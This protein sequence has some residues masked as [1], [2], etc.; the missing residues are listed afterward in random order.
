MKYECQELQGLSL[1]TEEIQK[2]IEISILKNL[3]K[4]YEQRSHP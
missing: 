2:N 3:K 1:T 4:C